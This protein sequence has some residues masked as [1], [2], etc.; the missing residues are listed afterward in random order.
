MKS[1]ED[2]TRTDWCVKVTSENVDLIK[3]VFNCNPKWIYSIG[4]YYGVGSDGVRRGSGSKS[5]VSYN[6]LTD[7]EFRALIHAET[8]YE[9]F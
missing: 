1:I 6:V 4:A 5:I 7:E 3:Q 9:I 8:K 2:I